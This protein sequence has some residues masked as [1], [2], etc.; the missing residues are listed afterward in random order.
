[1]KASRWV[2]LA[3]GA[4]VLLGGTFLAV[5]GVPRVYSKPKP[6]PVPS[7]GN[8]V[9]QWWQEQH[10]SASTLDKVLYTSELYVEMPLVN[11]YTR[12]LTLPDFLMVQGTPS[13]K[14]ADGRT[15]LFYLSWKLWGNAWIHDF[16]YQPTILRG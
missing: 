15:R 11:Q 4:T 6:F 8:V 16:H 9:Q 1:M 12:Q 10:S 13:Q 7:S 5:W 14:Y 2:A 3:T